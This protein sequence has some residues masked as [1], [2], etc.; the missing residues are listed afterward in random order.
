MWVPGTSFG[1]NKKYP[2]MPPASLDS[3]RFNTN[4]L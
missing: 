1:P 4:K 3:N 2:K